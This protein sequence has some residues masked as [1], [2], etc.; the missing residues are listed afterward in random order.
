MSVEQLLINYGQY[1]ARCCS[2][3]ISSIQ[4]KQNLITLNIFKKFL[5][6]L[7][8]FLKNHTNTQFKTLLDIVI[9]DYP[10]K[11][12]RFEV[13]YIF[14]SI[15]RNSRLL[16]KSQVSALSAIASITQHYSAAG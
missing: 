13:I 16:V 2:K 14:L 10:L 3:S 4:I 15:S 8:A 9:V 6:P 7:C 5:F 12:D 1:L 11:S